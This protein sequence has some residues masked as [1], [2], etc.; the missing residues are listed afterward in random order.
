MI[1]SN[2]ADFIDALKRA[3]KNYKR[4]FVEIEFEGPTAFRGYYVTAD[5]I[6]NNT[7]A[8]FDVTYDGTA[9]CA[10]RYRIKGCN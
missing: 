1:F 2:Y 7:D 10:V 5:D 6:E 4:V 9:R 8:Y 3:A